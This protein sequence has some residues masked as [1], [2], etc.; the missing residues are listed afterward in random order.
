MVLHIQGS[1]WQCSFLA[2]AKI[3]AFSN[4]G[5]GWR[6][7]LGSER[8]LKSLRL[9]V[10][11]R[12]YSAWMLEGW[13]LKAAVDVAGTGLCGCTVTTERSSPYC[14]GLTATS[15]CHEEAVSPERWLLTSTKVI[16]VIVRITEPASRFVL[17]LCKQSFA[18]G[19]SVWPRIILK[20]KKTSCFAMQLPFPGRCFWGVLRLAHL[21]LRAKVAGGDVGGCCWSILLGFWVCFWEGVNCNLLQFSPTLVGERTSLLSET[22]QSQRLW[23]GRRQTRQVFRAGVSRIRKGEGPT[24]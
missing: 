16:K 14:G 11:L 6:K 10:S 5:L 1:S 9:N 24:C 21:M 2:E 12:P 17:V 15:V 20:L 19:S 13:S 8:R 22:S 23:D 3:S 7:T 4:S 18:L